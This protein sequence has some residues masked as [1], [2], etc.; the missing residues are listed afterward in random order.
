MSRSRE[1]AVVP[2]AEFRS[3]YGRPVLKEPVWKWEIAAYLFTGGLTAGSALLAAGCDLIGDAG[4]ARTLRLATVAGAGA[5]TALL[6]A[7]LGRPDRFHHM[8]RVAKPTSPMSVGSWALAMFAPLATVA[9]AA[10]VSTHSPPAARFVAR[11]AGLGAAALAPLLAT[12]TAVLLAD[13][14]VPVWHDARREL[15][16]V[17]GAGAA[18]STGGLALLLEPDALVAPARGLLVGGG[19]GHVAASMAMKRRLSD[20]VARP[21]RNGRAAALTRAADAAAIVAVVLGAKAS[22][23]WVRRTAG[24]AALAAAALDRFA[25]FEAGR[26]SARDPAAVVMAQHNGARTEAV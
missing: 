1:R 3:Y 26:A 2:D 23:R 12:Y 16:F 6:V 11:A 24:A 9:A 8:L 10:G 22:R 4:S 19:V 17:F 15:P 25:V 5:S 21:Y 13:T 7:D 18:F 20:V 14:A